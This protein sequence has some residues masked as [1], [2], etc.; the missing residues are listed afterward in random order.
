MGPPLAILKNEAQS[1]GIVLR[2][3]GPA[4]ALL[5]RSTPE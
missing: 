2:A 3:A 5:I 4:P 1:E